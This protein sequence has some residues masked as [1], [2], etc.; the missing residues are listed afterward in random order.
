MKAADQEGIPDSLTR[1]PSYIQQGL[2]VSGPQVTHPACRCSLFYCSSFWRSPEKS[3]QLRAYFIPGTLSCC[4]SGT[5]W[6]QATE[7]SLSLVFPGQWK[8]C[9]IC[10][11]GWKVILLSTR[12]VEERAGNILSRLIPAI[13]SVGDFSWHYIFFFFFFYNVFKYV[14]SHRILPGSSQWALQTLRWV[15]FISLHSLLG[16]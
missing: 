12:F 9:K 5:S 16:S 13:T 6:P 10:I 14:E 11:F 4:S 7:D 3:L 8:M 15:V 1:A 2:Y